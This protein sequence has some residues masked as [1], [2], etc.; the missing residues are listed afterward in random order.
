MAEAGAQTISA[1]AAATD[2]GIFMRAAIA[3]AGLA[4]KPRGRLADAGAAW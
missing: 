1:S 4:A 2:L 3:A